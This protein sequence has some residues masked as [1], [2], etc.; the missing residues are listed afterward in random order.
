MLS[1]ADE[2]KSGQYFPGH[3]KRFMVKDPKLRE[4]WSAPFRDRVV[5]HAIYSFLEPIFD[6]TFIYY[7]FACRKE[8]GSHHAIERLSNFLQNPANIFLS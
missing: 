1:L 3:Y 6:R 2:L 5:H 7:S 4:I 8:K